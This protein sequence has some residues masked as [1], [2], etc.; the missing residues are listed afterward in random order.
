MHSH[1]RIFFLSLWLFLSHTH[2]S[3][4]LSCLFA[5]FL[6]IALYISMSFIASYGRGVSLLITSFPSLYLVASNCVCPFFP[7]FAFASLYISPLLS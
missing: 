5:L 2:T 6:W 3:K 7:R 1:A 4:F